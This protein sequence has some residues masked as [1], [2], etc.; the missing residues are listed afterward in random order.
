MLPISPNTRTGSKKFEIFER[1]Q[2]NAVKILSTSIDDSLMDNDLE[3]S[4]IDGNLQG[5]W[6]ALAK[7]NQMNNRVSISKKRKEFN[8]KKFEHKNETIQTFYTRL[9]NHKA[10]LASTTR[11]ISTDDVL[12]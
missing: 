12:E 10:K 2:E 3:L 5:M 6:N 1:K 8:N 7:Y 11:P 9:L 4:L